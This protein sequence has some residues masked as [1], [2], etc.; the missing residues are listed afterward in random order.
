MHRR[1]AACESTSL[2]PAFLPPTGTDRNL[3]GAWCL[4]R[5]GDVAVIKTASTL[6]SELPPQPPHPR[7]PPPRGARPRAGGVTP[8]LPCSRIPRVT[9]TCGRSWGADWPESK[10]DQGN[11]S[12]LLE[13]PRENG[14][15]LLL[16]P[17][18]ARHLGVSPACPAGCRLHPS[19]R[20]QGTATEALPR[21]CARSRGR[22][23]GQASTCRWAAAAPEA[24]PRRQEICTPGVLAISRHVHKVTREQHAV[25]ALTGTAWRCLAVQGPVRGRARRRHGP[26]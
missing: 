21:G 7:P 3:P 19:L 25:T 1:P 14:V 18:C 23:D 8:A 20:R 17:T 4:P 9:L 13:S 26:P 2:P 12:D 11:L 24:H 16:S 22:A 15:P 6:R 5:P 10:L